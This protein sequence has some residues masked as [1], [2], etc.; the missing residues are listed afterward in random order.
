M[1]DNSAPPCSVSQIFLQYIF[2]MFFS[3]S[4]TGWTKER[5]YFE[6]IPRPA[7][8]Y[9][10]GLTDTYTSRHMVSMQALH[11][12]WHSASTT[13]ESFR[14]GRNFPKRVRSLA[15]G[16][17]LRNRKLGTGF[18]P[19]VAIQDL[20]VTII[21]GSCYGKPSVRDQKGAHSHHHYF[22]NIFSYSI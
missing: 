5:G 4:T 9:S 20:M 14:L 11:G 18:Q 15:G 2:L 16:T 10:Y 12:P 21:D 17:E 3:W 8:K 13:A 7:G 1:G 19:S 22:R 6:G